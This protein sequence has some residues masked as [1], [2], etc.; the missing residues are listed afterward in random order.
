[1]AKRKRKNRL[2]AK[3]HLPSGSM[4]YVGQDREQ[5]TQIKVI[6]YNDNQINEIFVDNIDE[7]KTFAS[8]E[9]ISWISVTGI[10]DSEKIEAICNV[11][12][13]HS[14]VQEDI[15]NTQ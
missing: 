1:M 11:F 6:D 14:L 2:S 7:L 9:T 10:Q 5:A 4:V 8:S 15:L 3:S 13:I 12:D